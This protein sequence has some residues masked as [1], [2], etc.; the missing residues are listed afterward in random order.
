ME[1]SLAFRSTRM[2]KAYIGTSGWNHEHWWNGQ[3]YPK[4]LKPTQWMTGYVYLYF[5]N[6]LGGYA[7]RNAKYVR[8]ALAGS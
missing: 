5:N 4:E 6:D 1:V 3:F 2:A 8:E 7:I